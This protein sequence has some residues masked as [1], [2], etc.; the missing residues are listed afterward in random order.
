VLEAGKIVEIGSHEE[1]LALNG[2]Y[3]KLYE[4][5]RKVHA[6][7]GS[8]G[9]RREQPGGGGAG[10]DETENGGVCGGQPDAIA[11]MA[12]GFSQIETLNQDSAGAEKSAVT[13]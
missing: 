8:E 12:G 6:V 7:E 4:K 11:V 10:L 3:K 1:L 2:H 5:Q 9:A 13:Q